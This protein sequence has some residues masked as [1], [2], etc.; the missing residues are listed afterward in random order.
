MSYA[1]QPRGSI[2]HIVIGVQ[3]SSFRPLETSL[4]TWKDMS[5]SNHP[6][7]RESCPTTPDHA[8]PVKPMLLDSCHGDGVLAKSTFSLSLAHPCS[9][10][11][12][13]LPMMSP[14]KSPLTGCSGA[15]LAT[16][17]R[18]V[19]TPL[20][21]SRRCASTM[22][23]EEVHAPTPRTL[24]LCD[25]GHCSA[26]AVACGTSYGAQQTAVI[27]SSPLQCRP[28]RLDDLASPSPTSPG[29]SPS[30]CDIPKVMQVWEPV[31]EIP[32]GRGLPSHSRTPNEAERDPRKQQHRQ[33]SLPLVLIPMS[34]SCLGSQ[35]PASASE[36]SD[37][38]V[39]RH[40]PGVATL[41]STVFDP[42]QG[43]SSLPSGG[44]QDRDPRRQRR[45]LAKELRPVT[46]TCMTTP[47][48]RPLSPTLNEMSAPHVFPRSPANSASCRARRYR[49]PTPGPE[50]VRASSR[51]SRY[52]SPTPRPSGCK[53]S[54]SRHSAVASVR[55]MS[56]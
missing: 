54:D 50:R 42:R 25:C 10:P 11:K 24:I 39:G 18:G 37:P 40:A 8:T 6:Q 51:G 43:T 46:E 17:V 35:M 4:S 53:R 33:G 19:A 23:Q 55:G 56:L 14:M 5:L 36:V 34:K 12:R 13:Q 47:C 48:K 30:Q 22:Q 27:A 3:I 38:R 15:S 41:V 45:R 21:T 1:V 32:V 31:Q 20:R 7:S 28:L 16:S 26:C 49:S 29:L 44:H 9:T 2:A 52:R